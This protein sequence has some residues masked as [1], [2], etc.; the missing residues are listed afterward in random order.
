MAVTVTATRGDSRLVSWSVEAWIYPN[1]QNDWLVNVKAEIDLDDRDGNDRCV[2]NEQEIVSDS[3]AAGHAIRQAAEVLLGYPR[4]D[5][6]S[7]GWE[8]PDWDDGE[9][10][11]YG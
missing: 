8:P 9:A 5:L 3:T 2:V 1:G 7:D 10:P 4:E 6:L 11:E